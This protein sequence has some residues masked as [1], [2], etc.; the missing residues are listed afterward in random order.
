MPKPTRSSTGSVPVN[1]NNPVDGVGPIIGK[2]GQNE[3]KVRITNPSE[4]TDAVWMK[5]RQY[6]IKWESTD[7]ATSLKQTEFVSIYLVSAKDGARAYT[8]SSKSYHDGEFKWTVSTRL[9]DGIYKIVVQSVKNPSLKVT[10]SP[11]S[12]AATVSRVPQEGDLVIKGNGQQ[13]RIG[14]GGYTPDR[15]VWCCLNCY[16]ES[17]GTCG[18]CFTHCQGGLY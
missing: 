1:R 13:T 6:A 11:I 14:E 18:G 4:A 12:I 2:T 15:S 16:G 3:F 7:P 10:S 9:A 5:G 8:I 17:G